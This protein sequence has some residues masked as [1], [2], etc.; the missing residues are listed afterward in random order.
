MRKI[1]QRIKSALAQLFREE[2]LEYIGYRHDIPLHGINERSTVKDI[3]FETV[4]LEEVIGID[5]CAPHPDHDV[6][7]GIQRAKERMAKEILKHIH[8]STHDLIT[9][10]TKQSIRLKLRVQCKQ[11]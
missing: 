6:H 7:I 4:I 2:L 9:D 8:V 5:P 3:P 10:G 11:P 1:K